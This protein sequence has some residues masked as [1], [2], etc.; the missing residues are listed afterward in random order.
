MGWHNIISTIIVVISRVICQFF[1]LKW[2]TMS[3][4]YLLSVA[5]ICCVTD[6]HII[7]S[8]PLRRGVEDLKWFCQV[9]RTASVVDYTT[10]SASAYRVECV[11]SED[12][13]GREF[14]SALVFESRERILNQ[15]VWGLCFDPQIFGIFFSPL[16]YGLSSTKRTAVCV[17]WE[18]CNY[19]SDATR[20]CLEVVLL[21]LYSLIFNIPSQL[22][23]Y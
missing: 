13:D 10:V 12:R 8:S 22:V 14:L 3:K 23:C 17:G 21:A 15:G 18:R 6:R 2:K 5:C 16:I 7:I 19:R 20:W 9:G 1:V 11:E 4:H